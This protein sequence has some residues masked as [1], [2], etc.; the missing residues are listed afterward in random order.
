MKKR[1]K[2]ERKRK[3]YVQL[4]FSSL[5]WKMKQMCVLEFLFLVT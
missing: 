4:N 2:K 1:Q 3:K 5:V